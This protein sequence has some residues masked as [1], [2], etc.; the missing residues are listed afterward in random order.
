MKIAYTYAATLRFGGRP[1]ATMVSMGTGT[2][3]ARTRWELS[4][5]LADELAQEAAQ[6]GTDPGHLAIDLLR[7]H[8]PE[9]LAEALRERMTVDGCRIPRIE[10]GRAVEAD[11]DAE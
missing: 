5:E 6:R 11:H 8:L 10:N 1:I 7:R 3:I 2:S 4:P 9:A